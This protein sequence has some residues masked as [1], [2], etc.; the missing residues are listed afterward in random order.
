M[1]L[2]SRNSDKKEEVREP[3][4]PP[5]RLA[6]SSVA[7]PPPAPVAVAPEPPRPATTVASPSLSDEGTLDFP[8]I[9]QS[10][11]V[12]DTP[13]KAEQTLDMLEQLP[14]AMPLE[15]KRQTVHVTL[16]AL[17]TVIGA[18]RH[19]IVSDATQ[20]HSALQQFADAQGKKTDE[21]VAEA[22]AQIDELQR[23]ITQKESEIATAKGKQER[24]RT[25][26]DNEAARLDSV[27]SFFGEEAPAAPVVTPVVSLTLETTPPSDESPVS[28]G[29]DTDDA[30]DEDE[31]A[32]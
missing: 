9:Y 31:K 19:T 25:L 26:C 22:E 20:K 23:Q 8:A 29:E 28:L 16:T 10:A 24:V 18:N 2:F 14:A 32:A 17:G 5:V 7:P 3:E 12:T 13:F 27:L 21:Y 30:D 4:M 1:P 11:R 6:P 15:M